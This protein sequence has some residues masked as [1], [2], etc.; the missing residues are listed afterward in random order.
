M[1]KH[2]SSVV[3]APYNVFK[4]A[5]SVNWSVRFLIPGQG[6][7]RKSLGTRDCQEAEKLAQRFYYESLL[8]A[9]SGLNVRAKSISRIIQDY[10]AHMEARVAQV[11][12]PKNVATQNTAILTRYVDGFFG[13]HN[14]NFIS[15][16]TV[17][18]YLSWRSDY[19]IT[20]PGRDVQF[21]TYERNGKTITS[22]ITQKKRVRPTLATLNR[23]RAGLS[24]FF[25]FCLDSQYIKSIPE[26][27]TP[28]VGYTAR[29]GF[30]CEES[31]ASKIII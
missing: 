6:Q 3:S 2:S 19:W 27:R 4:Q 28:K 10:I 23:E 7:I 24:G 9:E 25:Q 18:A 8:K 5:G 22:P 20:G 11:R 12:L 16:K 14:P 13:A 1:D 29:P 21:M 15:S 31:H 30:S 26:I 17:D